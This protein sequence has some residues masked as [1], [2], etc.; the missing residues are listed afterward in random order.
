MKCTRRP[1][2]RL[3]RRAAVAG[4]SEGALAVAVE[5]ERASVRVGVRVL[6]M[7]GGIV[8]LERRN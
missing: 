5:E 8:H 1:A 3:A 2:K 6:S 7:D 4:S